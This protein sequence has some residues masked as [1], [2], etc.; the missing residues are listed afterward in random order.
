MSLRIDAVALERTIDAVPEESK[1][2]GNWLFM[3]FMEL[4]ASR[5]VKVESEGGVSDGRT[6]MRTRPVRGLFVMDVGLRGNLADPLCCVLQRKTPYVVVRSSLLTF[7]PRT[8]ALLNNVF[9][10]CPSR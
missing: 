7:H 4:G 3:F 1:T 2:R 9:A 10:V 5:K 8:L 6:R